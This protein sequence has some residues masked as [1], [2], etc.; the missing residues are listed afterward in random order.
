MIFK[1]I[2]PTVY[3]FI[4][5]ML[6]LIL[7]FL[8]PIKRIVVPPYAYLGVVI[9]LF[10]CILNLE[11]DRIFKKDRTTVKP[12]EIPS[13]LEDTGP[14]RISRHPMY[15]GMASILVGVAVILGSI[16]T[17]V[18]PLVFI[19]LMEILFIPDEDSNLERA[20]GDKYKSYKKRVRRWI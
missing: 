15:L 11:A 3:F 8:V 19:F 10:G 1:K 17:F 20:F 9:I 6:A 13:A 12:Y 4:L 18:P 2:M 5:L 14:F 7:H 16:V